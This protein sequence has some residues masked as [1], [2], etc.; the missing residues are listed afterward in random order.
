MVIPH[1]LKWY[2][3]WK[4]N[5]CTFEDVDNSWSS[6]F[7][8]WLLSRMS[9]IGCFPSPSLSLSF[10]PIPFFYEFTDT[11]NFSF[12]KVLHYI[13]N[14]LK[15]YSMFINKS[16]LEK[17]LITNVL[18]HPYSRCSL[19]IVTVYKYGLRVLLKVL[20]RLASFKI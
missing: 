1:R 12:L 10:S 3:W 9:S 19:Y 4:R 2:I 17:K 14:V 13:S 18:M 5:N 7:S 8:Q 20:Y 6:F 15:L 16:L 11:I